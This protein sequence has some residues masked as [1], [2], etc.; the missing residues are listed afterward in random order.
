[1]ERA[2]TS[3]ALQARVEER[4]RLLGLAR[5]YVDGLARRQPLLA[6]VVVGSVARGDFNVW[7]DVDVVVAER[8]PER[9]PDR[10]MFLAEDAPG[11]VQPIGFTPE[12]LVLAL[13]RG[14]PL[15]QEA[16]TGGVVLRGAEILK[17]CAALVGA[18]TG[19]VHPSRALPAGDP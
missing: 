1:M 10:A 14:N 6:A 11:G 5:S 9:A 8:L 15:A 3:K 16:V 13:R 19:G 17:R 4:E 2:L 7:S 18:A 12:E